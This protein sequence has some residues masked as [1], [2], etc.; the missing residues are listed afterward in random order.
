MQ[1]KINE[2]FSRVSKSYDFVNH[3][4]SFNIDKGWRRACAV[5]VLSGDGSLK[6]LDIAAGT[7]DL[8]ITAAEM[9][10]RRGKTAAIYAS[11]FNKEMLEIAK[12]KISSMGLGDRIEIEEG[13][14]FEI[15]HRSGTIDALMSGFALRSF[16]FSDGTG[17]NMGKFLSEAYRVIKPGGRAV[18]LDM[19]LPDRPSQ[20]AFFRLY[21]N[22]MLFAG[23]FVDRE[24]YRWLVKTITE[25]DKKRLK[26]MMEKA[27]FR[28][29]RITDLKSGI[30]YL[31]CGEK[32]S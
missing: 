19:A 14:A 23:A 25:F 20:R 16:F 11:D 8:S 28:N 27:G 21:S 15:N 18:L 2:M 24:T 1:D 10:V 13:N 17:E 30:A 12:K 32:H 9:A 26:S 5:Q 4:L 3:L 7:G 31:A 6:I 22:F 29:V